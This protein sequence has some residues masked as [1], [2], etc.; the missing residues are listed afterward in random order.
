MRNYKSNILLLALIIISMTFKSCQD[1]DQEFGAIIAPSNITLNFEIL[2]QDTENPNGD[3]SGIVNFTA[4]ADDALTYIYSY[5][6][7]TDNVSAPNGTS[8]HRFTQLGLNAYDVTVIASGTG[9]ATSSFVV[10]VE[11]FSAFD[12]LEAKSFLTGA[13]ITLDPNGDEVIDVSTP[14]LKIWVLD[15]S[16]TG[17]LGVGPS[18]AFDITIFETPTQ[19]Y[20]PSFFAAGPGTFCGNPDD[21]FCD[22]ELIFTMNTDGTLSYILDNKGETFFNANAAHQAIVGG[23]GGGDAC[24]AFDTS[25]ESIVTLAPTSENWEP[26]MALDQSFDPRGTVMNFSNGGFMSYYIG[27]SSY[28]ILSISETE[29]HV[30]ANDGAN[31]D[32]SWYLRFTSL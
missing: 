20:Y 9:G 23:A 1:E 17:H 13:P 21:C 14:V 30:R 8:T 25:T 28:E 6:D 24:V 16:K 18:A 7:G 19:Y 10:T 12:D 22:D 4:T 5:G 11:V 27:T 2:G 3:G 26:A 15:D 32:L 29:M 31:A